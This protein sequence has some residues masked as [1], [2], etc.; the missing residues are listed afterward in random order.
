MTPILLALSAALVYGT[1]DFLGGLFSR[2]SHFVPINLIGNLT[3]SAVAFT[4]LAITG[5]PALST[6]TLLWGLAAGL[7]SGV[8]GLALYRGLAKGEMAVVGPVSAV[9]AAVFPAAVGFTLGERFGALTI[10]GILLALPAIWLLAGGGSRAKGGGIADG[11]LDGLVAGAGFGGLF[12][13]IERAGTDSGLWPV[14]LAQVGALGPGL[15]ALLIFR[16]WRTQSNA[17]QL[18]LAPIPGFLVAAAILLYQISLDGGT[19]TISSVITSLYPGFTV[20]LAA[21]FLHERTSG[22]QRVGLALACVAVTLVV[23]G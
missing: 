1:A 15:V 14:A 20:L 2:R 6:S 10:I 19:L 13:G 23:L 7:G 12:I 4:A 11:A 21:W 22:T 5:V 8:G 18:R 16:S 17:K 3:A 9:G